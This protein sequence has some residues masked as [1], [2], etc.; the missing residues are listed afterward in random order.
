MK[1][2]AVLSI[3]LMTAVMV[4]GCVD[5]YRAP[6]GEK[7]GPEAERAV[8]QC[9]EICRL[10][11]ARGVDLSKGPCLSNQVDTD[12][13]CD[14]AHSPRQDVDNLPENQCSAWRDAQ[15]RGETMHFVEVDP[16]CTLIRAV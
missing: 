9:L 13:V 16:E 3:L 5:T 11:L 1:N 10:R 7:F 8:T 14:V 6:I 2:W 12:W 15:A 4:S